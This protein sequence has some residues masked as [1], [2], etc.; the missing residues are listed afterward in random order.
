MYKITPSEAMSYLN[1]AHELAIICSEKNYKE[2]IDKKLIQY[3]GTC[4]RNALNVRQATRNKIK[5][6]NKKLA[7]IIELGFLDLTENEIDLLDPATR[8]LYWKNYRE[9][10]KAISAI[11][12]VM[13]PTQFGINIYKFYK[14]EK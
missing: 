3:I 6:L 11:N 10:Q 4:A 14:R 5:G 13:R 12:D 7:E 2:N 9:N 8:K 1:A